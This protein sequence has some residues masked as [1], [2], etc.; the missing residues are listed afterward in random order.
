METILMNSQNSKTVESHRFKLDL[1][2]KRN[3]KDPKH[4]MAFNNSNIY[5]TCKNIRSITMQ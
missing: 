1:T 4:N 2:D 3:F 5:Y